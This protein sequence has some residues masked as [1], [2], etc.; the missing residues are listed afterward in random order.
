MARIERY[1]KVDSPDVED[2]VI[3]TDKDDSNQTK[4]FRLGDILAMAEGVDLNFTSLEDTPS[5][6]AN[7]AGKIPV[8][9]FEEQGLIFK[10]P[11]EV[12]NVGDL[13][14]LELDDTPGSYVGESLK[15]LRVKS[16]ELGVEFYDIEVVLTEI[17]NEINILES[18]VDDNSSAIAE[19]N[20]AFSQIESQISQINSEL[21]NKLEDA[22]SDGD[23]YVRKNGNW[24]KQSDFLSTVAI[25]GDYNDL[26]NKP[27]DLKRIININFPFIRITQSNT[28]FYW[29]RTFGVYP[30]FTLSTGKTD[31]N[32][33]VGS[34]SKSL[35]QVPFDCKIKNISF[36]SSASINN[37]LVIGKTDNNVANYSNVYENTWGGAGFFDDNPIMLVNFT[38][39]DFLIPYFKINTSGVAYSQFNITLEEL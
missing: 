33:L 25:S 5:T 22:P 20:A 3:G 2:I 27:E 37:E 28:V 16:D 36:L 34:A 11:T 31:K 7:S 8:V 38:K 26:N 14:L 24:V 17:Q 10:D 15:V 39:G 1:N 13:T 9:R 6:Y 32:T 21:N 18:Q 29:Q 23:I 4:N 12:F 35:L 30:D 19:L